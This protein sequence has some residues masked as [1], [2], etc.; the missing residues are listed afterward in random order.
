MA[1]LRDRTSRL[2]GEFAPGDRV[3]GALITRIEG[4]RVYLL[5]ANQNEFI[6]LLDTG[7][8]VEPSQAA[9]SAPPRHPADPTSQES[10]R[11]IRK[12]GD[13]SYEIQ[14]S[15][16][17]GFLGNMNLL[18]RS[19]RILPEVRDGRPAGFRLTTVAPQGP[20]AKIGLQNSDLI[21]SINGL[22]LASAEKALE[23][24]GKLRSATHLSLELERQG[25]RTTLDYSVR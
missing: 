14:R 10:E 12:L 4:T 19:A 23:A 25:K 20:F 5:H 3:P 17:D 6:D 13:R 15:T 1:V 2:V 9:A 22:E 8:D 18:A 16:L 21:V 11:G 24:Y 7:A